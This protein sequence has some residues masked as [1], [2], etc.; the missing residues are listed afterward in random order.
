MTVIELLKTKTLELRKQRS[1]LG[2]TMQFHMAEVAKIG[3][4]NGNRDTTED[5]A[6][7]YLKKSVQKLKENE[8]ADQDEIA[9]LEAM[10]PRMAT[11]DEVRAHVFHLEATAG[12]DVSNK[13]AV[14]KAVKEQ[15][16][17]LVDM[18]MVGSML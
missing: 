11:I 1:P 14:M 13:G 17:S 9:V 4:S 3:K 7:Q 2:P 6:V 15:F 16:G 10:L 18:K 12:L 8:F 5:E